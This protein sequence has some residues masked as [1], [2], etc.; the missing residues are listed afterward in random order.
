M[1]TQK[2]SNPSGLQLDDIGDLSELLNKNKK[3]SDHKNLLQLDLNL[4]EEDPDQP[5]K[6]ENPGFA[7]S[8]LKELANTIQLRG[9]KSPISVRENQEKPGYFIIN[10]GARRYRASRI[11]GK[12]SIPAFIDNEYNEADQVIENLQRNELTAREIADY[13][14]REIAKGKK[15]SKIAKEIGK[16]AAFISQHFTLL[17]LPEPIAEA[18]HSGRV[19]DVTVVNELVRL[20]KKSP[21]KVI[22]WLCDEDQELTRK[23]VALIRDYIEN[24]KQH[25]KKSEKSD[26]SND[27]I[28]P[29]E[30]KKIK[31]EGT[32]KNQNAN[33]LKKA[34]VSIRH[35]NQTG[36]I[37]L[38]RRPGREGSAWIKYEE[39]GTE[40]EVSLSNVEL[41]A[42]IEGT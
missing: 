16:S 18:F 40:S 27:Q 1:S 37:M 12:G 9:V 26:T 22:T 36:R 8:S 33:K 38:D 3:T 7:E 29:E 35:N 5:R 10:H 30:D 21:D 13:I 6:E 19:S 2:K 42:L 11:A 32:E 4:I 20:H 17:N 15:K 23:S 25:H 39:D 28:S 14:G 34:I 24:K 41:I 31:S